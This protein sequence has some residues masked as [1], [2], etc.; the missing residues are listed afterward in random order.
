MLNESR[1]IRGAHETWYRVV[2]DLDTGPTPVV[3]CHG[4]PG[5][6]HDYVEPIADLSRYSRGCVL[7]DQVGCGRSTHLP[8]SSADFWTVQLFKDE[9]ADLTRHL[10]IADRY[11]VVGQSWGGMLARSRPP[12][13][14]PRDRRRRLAG[15]HSTLGRG[16]KPPPC[17]PRARRSSDADAA[18]RGGDDRL[19][20]IRGRSA[21][22]LR[23]APLPRPGSSDSRSAWVSPHHGSASTS[24]SHRRASLTS[25]GFVSAV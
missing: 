8:D 13:G 4:G 21:R 2:G 19:T 22:L 17:R 1:M 24:I 7:Y 25:C 10:G 12:A 14:P 15:Q 20:R 3:I 5:A 9:L 6:A 11:A 23:P 16:G 18:R